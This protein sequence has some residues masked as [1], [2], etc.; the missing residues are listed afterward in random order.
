MRVDSIAKRNGGTVNR[1]NES[2]VF[3]TEVLMRGKE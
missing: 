3:A 2:G 1:Q